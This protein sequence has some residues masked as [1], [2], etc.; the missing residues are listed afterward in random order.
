M[1]TTL[2]S[3]TPGIPGQQLKR[4]ERFVSFSDFIAFDDLQKTTKFESKLH[5][6]ESWSTKCLK[7]HEVSSSL[8]YLD[9]IR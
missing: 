5:G 8:I 4:S 2:V 9:N 3:S 6:Q 7:F 1:R